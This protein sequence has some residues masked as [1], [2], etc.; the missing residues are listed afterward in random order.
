VGLLVALFERAVGIYAELIDVNAYHQPAVDKFAGA[1]V[2]ELQRRVTVFLR[3]R[4]GPWTAEQVAKGIK[5]D[6]DAELVQ[7]L[8][9][10]LAAG[11]RRGVEVLPGD[12]RRPPRFAATVP[13]SEGG[14]R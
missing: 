3:A 2:L 7:D 8:L 5:A 6:G 14:A 4:P 12:G 9:R 1:D 13:A 11:G 10:R